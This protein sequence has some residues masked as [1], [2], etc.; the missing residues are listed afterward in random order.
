MKI[1]AREINELLEGNIFITLGLA[2]KLTSILGASLEFWMLRDYQFWSTKE[3]LI[4]QNISI[5]PRQ[6]RMDI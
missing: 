6:T 4:D 2:R 3:I 1:T 5:E